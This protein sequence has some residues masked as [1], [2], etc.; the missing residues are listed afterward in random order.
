[1]ETLLSDLEAQICHLQQPDRIEAALG[2]SSICLTVA[3]ERKLNGFQNRCLRGIIGVKPSY[4]SRVSNA[5]VLAR[6]GHTLATQLLRRRQM[7]LLGRVLQSGD[8]H[9]S[10][11]VTF[12]PG[13]D[14]PLT[15]RFVR[16]RGAPGEEWLRTILPA[17]RAEH[18]TN[19]A[20]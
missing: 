9:P 7:Q 17:Y 4:I 14:Y 12:I 8:G 10:R 5:V 19:G 2:L 18:N 1:M 3:Q 16:R 11:A 13:T 20:P 6:S 15:E